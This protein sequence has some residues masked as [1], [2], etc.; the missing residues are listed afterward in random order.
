MTE[1]NG[2]PEEISPP[3]QPAPDDLG[4]QPPL[5][6]TE[7]AMQ[8]KPAAFRE[9]LRNRNFLHLWL[10]QIV[11]AIGDWVIVGALFA[12]VYAVSGG[13]NS[14]VS[15]M[16]LARF[17]PAVLLG[18]VAGV[19]IDRWERKS[20]LLFSDLCR[21][22]LVIVFAFTSTMWQIVI[23]TFIMETFAI[24][25][26][27]AKDASI[28]LIVEREQLMNANSLS[29]V[30]LFASMALGTAMAGGVIGL[31]QVLANNFQFFAEHIHP[32][33]A[34][35]FVDA[36]TFM[37]SAYL[38]YKLRFPPRDE[39]R[40]LKISAGD[41][42]ND[43]KDGFRYMRS[44]PL[45]RVVLFLVMISFLGGGTV[46]VLTIGF[47]HTVLNRGDTSFLTILTML[48]VGMMSGAV[49]AG[50]LKSRVRK[51]RVIGPLSASFGV[52][53]VLFSLNTHYF[54]LTLVMCFF[55]GNC[56]GYSA[57][58]MLTL[59]HENLVDEYRGRVFS[60]VS[61]LMRGSIFLSIVLAGPL[62]DLI[63]RYFPEVKILTFKLNSGPQVVLMG[64]GIIITLAG[65]YATRALKNCFRTS[66]EPDAALVCEGEAGA[67]RAGGGADGG[68]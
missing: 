26:N 42:K 51:E 68:V 31:F 13:S 22:A 38:I 49:A 17:L 35:F 53:I 60:A 39:P 19:F 24:I 62:A 61:T 20:I 54:W 63:T 12:L 48:L 5:G 32:E 45:T 66:P 28:P 64:G 30:S 15:I 40:D 65:V 1:E 34:V 4:A 55:A 16:M 50:A 23:L 27:P 56:L 7:D 37:L 25:Y 43:L 46:Y 10:G 3:G 44:Q 29:Q 9:L 67:Q 14:A 41:V 36:L 2:V 21:A 52:G 33:K 59:L 8:I 57:V 47:T 18:F 6:R 11:S 58:G